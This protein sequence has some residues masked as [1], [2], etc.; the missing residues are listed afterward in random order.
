MFGFLKATLGIRVSPREEIEGLDYHEHGM[1]AYD[2]SSTPP[3]L[4]GLAARS[5]HAVPPSLVLQET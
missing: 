4:G 1:H 3:E 2:V 5:E